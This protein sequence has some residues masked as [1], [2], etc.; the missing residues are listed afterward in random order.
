LLGNLVL[1]LLRVEVLL[2]EQE[3][4]RRLLVGVEDGTGAV[5]RGDAEL[6]ARVDG[7]GG[8][9]DVDADQAIRLSVGDQA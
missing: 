4:G 8:F 5:G 1:Q 2:T 9:E 7:A 3:R 6:L